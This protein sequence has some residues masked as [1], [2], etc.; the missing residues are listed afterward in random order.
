[1]VQKLGHLWKEKELQGAYVKAEKPV[2][3]WKT[4]MDGS[5]QQQEEG[6]VNEHFGARNFMVRL[7][8]QVR[9]SV[10]R[11][12]G[13]KDVIVG[14]N[15]YLFEQDYIDLYYGTHAL[16]KEKIGEQIRKLR[17]LQDTF[18]KKGI[19][20]LVVFT[21][22]KASFYP[23]FIP[24]ASKRRLVTRNFDYYREGLLNSKV[25]FLDL[26][27]YFI[28]LKSKS[29]YPLYPQSATHW[30]VYASELAA[31]TL[32]KCIAGLRGVNLPRISFLK[33]DV[34]DSLHIPDSDIEDGMNLLFAIPKSKLAYPVVRVNDSGASRPRVLTIGDSFFWGIYGSGRAGQLFT[35]PHFWY[36]YRELY[37]AGKKDPLPREEVNLRQEIEQQ[38]V[39]ILFANDGAADR[40]GWGFIDDAYSLYEKK[41]D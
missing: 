37:G 4:W 38:Q 12:A 28:R 18:K 26:S 23:E 21:P 20:L 34:S 36:Y 24:D 9:F 16:G 14:K 11:A 10:F 15:D 30:S 27:T 6:Y 33:I 22:E 32:S 35:S 5:F 19:D 7:Y 17:F 31:D 13:A 1:M 3:S 29:S 39:I 25:H 40:F 2:F 8:N 41:Q